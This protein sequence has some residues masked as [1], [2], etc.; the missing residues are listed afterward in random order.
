[1]AKFSRNMIRLEDACE[2][3]L[4]RIA[5]EGKAQQTVE[6][7]RYSLEC[8]CKQLGN[9]WVHLITDEQMDKY[10]YGPKGL[11]LGKR[12]K[13]VKA[14][15]FNRYLSILKGF[16]EH[17]QL[18]HWTDVDPMRSIKSARK[19]ASPRKL[20]LSASEL[21]ALLEA[22]NSPVE[23]IACALGMNTGLRSN[24]IRHLTIGDVSLTA[25]LIQT[26]IR[27]TKALDD[28][29]ITADLHVELIRWLDTYAQLM[30]LPSRADLPNHWYLVP[31][32]KA[33]SAVV[34]NGRYKLYPER[35]Y[36]VPWNLV[37]RPLSRIGHDP[38]GEGFHTL[39]RSSARLFFERLRSQGEGRDHALMIVKDYLG[40]ANTA[41][42]EHYLGLSVERTLRSKQLKGQSFISAMAQEEQ[43][44]VEPV[45][46]LRAIGG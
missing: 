41:M 17:A 25:G 43:A 22:C 8:L 46:T 27:K 37:K 1:M 4:Q 6:T 3:Y 33:P 23:R 7:S 45:D 11:R 9:P 14:A 44:R 20:L 36:T 21:T 16:F 30:D 15:S 5:N 29:E 34:P 2:R 35:M 26:E 19:E 40:H 31:V 12:G 39:R 13:P 32:Y 10:C 28:K 42:T 38:S 24:D 18:M